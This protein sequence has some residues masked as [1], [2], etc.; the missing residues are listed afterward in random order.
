MPFYIYI[1]I[2]LI[3]GRWMIDEMITYVNYSIT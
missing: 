1:P 3:D 2:D